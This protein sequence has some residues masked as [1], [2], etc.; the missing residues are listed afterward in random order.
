MLN[1][2]LIGL[3]GSALPAVSGWFWGLYI[4][5]WIIWFLKLTIEMIIGFYLV[6]NNK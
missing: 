5:S 1:L 3:L 2:I 4:T 6:K